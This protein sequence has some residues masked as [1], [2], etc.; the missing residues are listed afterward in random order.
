M[1]PG[2]GRL[3]RRSGPGRRGHACDVTSRRDGR[4]RCYVPRPLHIHIY[5]ISDV[6]V[7]VDVNVNVR[8]GNSFVLLQGEEKEER[9][10]KTA[11]VEPIV[12]EARL[13]RDADLAQYKK[14]AIRKARVEQSSSR[15]SGSRSKSSGAKSKSSSSSSRRK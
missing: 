10:L 11:Y 2:H 4:G 6:D 14:D 3:L 7:D 8:L 13:A 9:D 15:S 12:D 1:G 5:L